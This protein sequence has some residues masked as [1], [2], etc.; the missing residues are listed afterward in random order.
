MMV[1]LMIMLTM[2]MMMMV[3]M[4]TMNTH[5]LHYT[6]SLGISGHLFAEQLAAVHVEF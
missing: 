2:M 3:I 5:S 4:I 6:A 1:I